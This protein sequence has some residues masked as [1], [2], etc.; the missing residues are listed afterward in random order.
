MHTPLSLAFLGVGILLIIL[1]VN[2]ADSF[3]SNLSEFFTN[4]PTDK[5]IWLLIGGIASFLIGLGGLLRSSNPR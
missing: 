5:A 2:A 1:G 3:S 4:A